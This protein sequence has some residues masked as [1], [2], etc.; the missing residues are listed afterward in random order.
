MFN[1]YHSRQ[2]GR[3]DWVVQLLEGDLDELPFG[4]KEELELDRE[5]APWA[6]SQ[7][8]LD[9]FWR[10]RLASQ[11]IGLQLAG[12]SREE[13]QQKL[14][15]RQQEQLRRATQ[16]HERDIFQFFMTALTDAY[17]P[18]TRF[19][20]PRL[21]DNFDMA[22][23]LSFEGIG[24][25]AEARRRVREDRAHHPWRPCRTRRAPPSRRPHPRSGS[26]QRGLDGGHRR[27]AAR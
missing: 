11:I 16:Y 9:S 2:I 14:L 18:H 8:E 15:E 7:E 20:V 19:M 6:Q 5:A 23:S 17:D 27:L 22:M 26:G 21:A 1:R 4:G 12:S 25:L 13:A 10:K 24:A 3:L